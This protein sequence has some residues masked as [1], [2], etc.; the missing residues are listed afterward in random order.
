MVPIALFTN[1]YFAKKN[2]KRFCDLFNI[3]NN[4]IQ[5]NSGIVFYCNNVSQPLQKASFHKISIET[6]FSSKFL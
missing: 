5:N 2:K 4:I 6:L 3:H 1:L